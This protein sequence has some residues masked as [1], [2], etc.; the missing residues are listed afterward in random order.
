MG[1]VS[2]GLHS[3][4]T[5][6]ALATSTSPQI[7]EHVFYLVD[8]GPE[9]RYV[10]LRHCE[11]LQ[12]SFVVRGGRCTGLGS[13]GGWHVLCLLWAVASGEQ[14]AWQICLGCAPTAAPARCPFT[15]PCQPQGI[16]DLKGERVGWVGGAWPAA[17][18]PG[19]G[20]GM[21]GWDGAG[22]MGWEGG[23][24]LAGPSTRMVVDRCTLHVGVSLMAGRLDM[25]DSTVKCSGD[26][27]LAF[28]DTT[29]VLRR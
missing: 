20:A 29:L 13:C 17:G 19:E 14:W 11:V 8:Q 25:V 15:P 28:P 24:P 2:A 10:G 1:A 26:A 21:M 5:A 7:D 12:G 4:L 9:C 16:Q 27:L 22:M 6:Q 3:L 18:L 23:G